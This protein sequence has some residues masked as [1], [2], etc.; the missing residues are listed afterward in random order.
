MGIP[1]DVNNILNKLFT[2]TLV[3][4]LVTVSD[5]TVTPKGNDA[6]SSYNP[7]TGTVTANTTAAISLKALVREYTLYEVE[8]SN[9]ILRKGDIQARILV[10]DLAEI[11]PGATITWKSNDYRVADVKRLDLDDAGL[12]H[13]CLGRK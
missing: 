2:N 3:P 7:L 6:G 5:V 1:E 8:R 11:L 10:A 9:G 4:G 13:V 12:M